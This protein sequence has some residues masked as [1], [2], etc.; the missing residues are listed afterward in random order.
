MSD[1]LLAGL[2]LALMAVILPAFAAVLPRDVPPQKP[3]P[4]LAALHLSAPQT[5]AA[6]ASPRLSDDSGSGLPPVEI[7]GPLR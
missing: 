7:T 3:L 2:I 4:Q 1:K 6:A 5:V